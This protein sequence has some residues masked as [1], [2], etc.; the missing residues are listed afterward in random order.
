MVKKLLDVIK[1]Y[2]PKLKIYFTKSD[3]REYNYKINPFTYKLR[4]GKNI[5]LKKY[6]N[7]KTAINK[8]V[9]E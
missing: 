1:E 7:I 8:L 2:I 4:E 5:R 6:I 3:N 9:K